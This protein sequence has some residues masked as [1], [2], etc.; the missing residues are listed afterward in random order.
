MHNGQNRWRVDWGNLV[1][2]TVI[3]AA[4]LAYLLE[5]RAVSLSPHNLLLLQPTALFMFLLWAVIAVSCV[6]RRTAE[7]EAP[8][9]R[10]W[11]GLARV[12]GMVAAFG[13]FI[14][15]LETV[16]YDIA[17]WVFTVTGLLIGG[18]R[19]ILVLA[20]FPAIFAVA[21][22]MGFRALVPYPFPTSLL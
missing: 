6:R 10:D 16:G 21:V 3:A 14:A 4:A 17:I 22:I 15:S 9:A 7:A 2:V 18:E 1:L 11:A 13:A 5:A 8:T 20:L 12:I 19:R